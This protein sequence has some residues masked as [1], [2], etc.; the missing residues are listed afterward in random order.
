MT[1]TPINREEKAM[2]EREKM[3]DKVRALMAKTVENGCTEQEEMAALAKAR[4]LIDAFEI[5]DSELS[6]TKEEKA[7]FRRE[8]PGTRDP[9]SIKRWLAS[10]VAQFTDCKAWRDRDTALVFCG[11]RPDAQFA[12]WLLDHLAAFVLRELAQFL[13]EAD[14]GLS[15]RRRAIN[16]FVIG[17]T[18]RISKRLRELCAT[19]APVTSNAKALVVVKGQA[20]AAKM[21]EAGIHLGKSRSS[22][23]SV[24]A[25]SFTAGQAAGERASFG[26]PVSGNQGAL[27]IGGR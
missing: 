18:G 22:R 20:I 3:L 12:S 14:A 1:A 16:S 9:H 6:L 27:R 21:A 13:I 7:V 15:N 11:L 2:S 26:R 5:S 23:R 8:P 19:S 17:C 24:D 10:A 4:A 25:G